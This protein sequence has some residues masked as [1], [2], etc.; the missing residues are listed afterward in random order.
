MLRLYPLGFAAA[1]FGIALNA[2]AALAQAYP[3]GPPHPPGPP[4]GPG[5]NHPPAPPP[6]PGPGYNH[7]PGPPPGAGYHPPP[8]PV[9]G[10]NHPPGPPPGYNHPPEPP[11]GGWHQWHQGDHYSG[12]RV[13]VNNYSYYRL[14]PPPP[15]YQWVQDGSQFVL[16][17]VASG[18]IAD[19]ILNAASQ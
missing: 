7:P 4:P 11:P 5:Y 12:N 18:I 10:Y 17:A 3:P 1:M 6:P 19:V 9:M 13:V 15:G 2:S 14:R 8:P 16:V